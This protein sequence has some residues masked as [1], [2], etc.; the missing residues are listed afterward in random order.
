LQGEKIL[1]FI[2]M[3]SQGKKKIIPRW[4]QRTQENSWEPE[5]LISGI[6]LLALTQVPRLLDDLLLSLEIWTFNFSGNVD[7]KLFGLL[8]AATYWLI[9][10]LIVHLTLRSIWLSFVGLSY[11]F[12]NG[13]NFDKLRFQPSMNQKLQNYQGFEGSVM[14]LERICSMIY[15]IAFLLVM[16]TISAL[17]YFTVMT[18][19]AVIFVHLFQEDLSTDSA[20]DQVMTFIVIFTGLPYLI[21]FLTLGSLKR[22]RWFWRIYRPIYLFMSVITFASLYRGIYYGLV[23][24]INRW[25]LITGLLIFISFTTWRVQ[26][27]GDNLFDNT[28]LLNSQ[29]TSMSADEGYYRDK[30]PKRLSIWAHIQ[31]TVIEND[32]LELFVVHKRFAEGQIIR[33]CPDYE[34]MLS[35]ANQRALI[36]D[37]SSL[38]TLREDSINFHCLTSFYSIEIDGLDFPV[39]QWHMHKMSELNQQGILTWLDIQLLER[40]Q[41]TLSLYVHS[42]DEKSMVANIPFFKN[43][44]ASGGNSIDVVLSDSISV[45]NENDSQLDN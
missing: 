13:I 19:V 2:R 41:H 30:N 40:G 5:I 42:D 18:V 34:E 35:D 31:S 25:I 15:S 20:L 8:K 44:D 14:R 9:L 32:V 33:L 17:V 39:E 23:S 29:S 37:N 45:E 7:D 16:A 6:V 12:P 1:T 10:M 22:I 3:K 27:E 28:T 24:N 4:L 26:S 36:D 38:Q 11:A 43:S 21:D